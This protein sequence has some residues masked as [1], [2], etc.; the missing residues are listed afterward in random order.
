MIEVVWSDSFKRKYK[1]LITNNLQLKDKFAERI[2]EF[3]HYPF[4]QSLK[5]HKLSG[6]LKE[7]WSFSIDYHI[8]VIFRFINDSKVILLTIGSHN[9]VY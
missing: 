5:T 4:S 3:S 8:R 2:I 7:Y 9:E 6:E 1:K